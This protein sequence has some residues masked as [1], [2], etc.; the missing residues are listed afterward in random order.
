MDDLGKA[1]EEMNNQFQNYI[2]MQT[3]LQWVLVIAVIG[4][5]IW[6]IKKYFKNEEDKRNIERKQTN[7][8]E[9]I[10]PKF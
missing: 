5:T 4:I 10:D 1:A 9:R 3:L 8:S 7:R 2:F 6:T